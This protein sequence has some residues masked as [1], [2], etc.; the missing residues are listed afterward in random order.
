MPSF[1][2]LEFSPY[3]FQKPRDFLQLWIPAKHNKL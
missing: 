1:D 3:P 2:K